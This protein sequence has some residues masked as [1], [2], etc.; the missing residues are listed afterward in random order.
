MNLRQVNYDR[1][2]IKQFKQ[3]MERLGIEAPLE[4]MGQGFQDMSPAVKAFQNLAVNGRIRH[5]NHPLLRWCFS[6]AAVVRDAADNCKLDKSKVLRPH[7]RR[8]RRHHGDRRAQGDG[9][10]GIRAFP[11]LIG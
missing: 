2:A 8:G 4:P 1:W 7:R 10:A 3:T 5:G 6:N 11:R 9:A